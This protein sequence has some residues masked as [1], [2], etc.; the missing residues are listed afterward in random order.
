MRTENIIF[1]LPSSIVEKEG[2]RPNGLYSNEIDCH[3][4][5][6]LSRICFPLRPGRS[7][8][9]VRNSFQSIN[10]VGPVT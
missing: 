5:V 8:S 1:H 3:P 7:L 10:D 6:C 9:D 4:S 2:F